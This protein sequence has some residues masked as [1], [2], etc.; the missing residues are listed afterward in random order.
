MGGAVWGEVANAALQAV[1]SYLNYDQG[2]RANVTNLKLQ[3]RQQ[4]WEESMSNTAVQR[5]AADIEAAGGNRALAFVNGSEATTPVIAPAHVEAP[6]FD[7]PQINT[8]R[9]MQAAMLKS[10]INNLSAQTR[11]STEQARKTEAET[12]ETRARTL[13]WL[14]TGRKVEQET[15]NL[16]VMNRK[17]EADLSGVLTE[18]QLRQVKLLVANSTRADLIKKIRSGAII[19][20]LGIKGAEA[21][22]KIGAALSDIAD[23]VEKGWGEIGNLIT[24]F[25]ED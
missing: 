23:M 25:K 2:R 18:N 11:L 3:K 4:E 7:V 22:S 8:A 9:L 17:L 12:M 24:P 5:R 10:Q 20:Q 21:K 14:N 16:Q 6:R 19:E 1:G 15:S 13:N